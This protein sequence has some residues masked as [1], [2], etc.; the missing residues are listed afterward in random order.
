[1]SSL[2]IGTNTTI[3]GGGGVEAS[4]MVADATTTIHINNNIGIGNGNGNQTSSPLLNGR[5]NHTVT[6]TPLSSDTLPPAPSSISSSITMPSMAIAISATNPNVT[7]SLFSPSALHSSLWRQPTHAAAA[8]LSIIS[9]H[10]TPVTDPSMA[11]ALADSAPL[12]PATTAALMASSDPMLPASGLF[13]PQSSV[14][15]SPLLRGLA[16]GLSSPSA[17]SPWSLAANMDRRWP[18]PVNVNSAAAAAA[19]SVSSLLGS[20]LYGGYADALSTSQQAQA[21][22]LTLA[23]Q[24]RGQQ[25]QTLMY[26]Q[27]LQAAQQQAQAQAQ[28]V[29]Q[30]QQQQQQA[31]AHAAAVARQQQQTFNATAT[32]STNATNQAQAWPSLLNGGY[33]SNATTSAGGAGSSFDASALLAHLPSSAHATLG[34]NPELQRL[35]TAHLLQ[36]QQQ[37]HLLA[38]ALRNTGT[39]SSAAGI[40]AASPVTITTHATPAIDASM[41]QVSSLT[42]RTMSSTMAP[43]SSTVSMQPPNARPVTTAAVATRVSP[44]SVGAATTSASPQSVRSPPSPGKLL[45]GSMPSSPHHH[46]K[47]RPAKKKATKKSESDNDDDSDAQPGRPDSDPKVSQSS[48]RKASTS[49]KNGKGKGNGNSNNDSSSP[50]PSPSTPRRAPAKSAS[51]PK[52]GAGNGIKKQEVT[53]TDPPYS[54]TS[55]SSTASSVSSSQFTC[56]VAGCG[57]TLKTRFSLKRHMKKHTGEK[58]HTCPYPNCRK[59]F[60]ESST[61]KVILS[62]P[63]LRT[64]IHCS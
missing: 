30:Q 25:L 15:S 57:E 18:A 3:V 29:Q 10:Q 1:V 16:S 41:P 2:T 27:Q 62:Y 63:F 9:G 59:K 53:D 35:L 46:N 11:W 37:Q 14:S 20:G 5:V 38:A 45:G 28:A 26:M 32:A 17:H 24:Q 7:D 22:A 33:G 12:P 40:T 52:S 13:S 42:S 31:H 23:L 6:V 49:R 64:C 54:S 4:N 8:G 34:S 50:S 56:T 39:S 19:A 55:S 43:S 48:G 58:P 60:P 51:T 21:S 47:R 44:G 36:H 61:L